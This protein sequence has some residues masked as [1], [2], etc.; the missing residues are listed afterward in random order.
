[1]N[2]ETNIKFNYRVSKISTSYFNAFELPENELTKLFEEPGLIGLQVNT[3]I[4]ISTDAKSIAID[5]ESEL[6]KK[7]NKELLI[8]HKGRTIFSVDNL[9]DFFKPESN[10]FNLPSNVLVQLF[11]L[12]YT[13]ARA[14][15]AI[16]I[17]PTVYKDKFFLPIV[18]PNIMIKAFLNNDSEVVLKKE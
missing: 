4:N 14:L 8:A 1:M 16:E 7:V 3:A 9:Q 13:H 10:S 11:S 18:D 15:I 17:S 2:Q 6:S 5:I 12:A